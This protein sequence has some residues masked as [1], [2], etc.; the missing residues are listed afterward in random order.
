MPTKPGEQTLR[1]VELLKEHPT[2]PLREIAASSG[3]P[4]TTLRHA[5]A[6]YQL[7]KQRFKSHSAKQVEEA[8]RYCIAHPH[9]ISESIA[10]RFHLSDVTIG[11]LKRNLDIPPV[12]SWVRGSNP[13]KVFF[14]QL[15]ARETEV[16]RLVAE[17]YANLNIGAILGI[18]EETVKR[19]I[20]NVFLKSGCASRTQLVVL[21]MKRQQQQEM[22]LLRNQ[23]SMLQ[24]KYKHLE[25]DPKKLTIIAS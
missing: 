20:T 12:M 5:N 25:R 10:R 22:M 14:E 8:R 11:N 21:Y 7:G 18:S 2:E 24:R 16:V 3:I 6:N 9:E 4:L 15:S 23:M 13:A 1:A 19:H 17:G